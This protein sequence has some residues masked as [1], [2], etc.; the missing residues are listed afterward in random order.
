MN[1]LQN[2]MAF[3]VEGAVA[4]APYQALV[5]YSVNPLGS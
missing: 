2:F 5:K 3:E 1:Y 4:L